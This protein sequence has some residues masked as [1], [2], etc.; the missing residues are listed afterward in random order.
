MY[1]RYHLFYFRAFDVSS[2]FDV[3]I[4]GVLNVYS[5]FNAFNVISVSTVFRY[6]FKCIQCMCV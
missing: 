6:V 5:V 1:L 4:L 2:A 3:F